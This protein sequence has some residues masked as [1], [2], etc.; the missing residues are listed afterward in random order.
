MLFVYC[1]HFLQYGQTPL[2][3]A[4]EGG[5]LAVVEFLLEN[6]AQLDAGGPVR[7]L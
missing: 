4:A 5:H 6:G 2:Y 3:A 1:L 7:Q